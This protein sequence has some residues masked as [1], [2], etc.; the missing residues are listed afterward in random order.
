V[1][2]S[3]RQPKVARA[4]FDLRFAAHPLRQPR[5]TPPQRGASSL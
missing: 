2:E 1:R 5:A 4:I 3:K